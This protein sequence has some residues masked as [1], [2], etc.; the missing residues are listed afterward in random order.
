MCS[1]LMGLTLDALC[2]Y[3]KRRQVIHLLSHM[4]VRV[5][6]QVRVR[7]RVRVRLRVRVRVSRSLNST[8]HRISFNK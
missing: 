7:V 2:Y 3:I 4:C 5:R 8:S 6:V 1:S